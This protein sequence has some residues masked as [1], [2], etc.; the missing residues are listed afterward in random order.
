M[1]AGHKDFDEVVGTALCEQG[2]KRC[3]RISPTCWAHGFINESL[4]YLGS[5][6]SSQ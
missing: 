2:E 5:Q 1:G 3:E 4:K 6:P